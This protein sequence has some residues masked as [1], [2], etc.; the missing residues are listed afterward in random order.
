MREEAWVNKDEMLANL[1]GETGV[2]LEGYLEEEEIS[3]V[4]KGDYGIFY[5]ENRDSEPSMFIVK[6]IETSGSSMLNDPY[7]ASVY[8]GDI[9]VRLVNGD[10]LVSN[11]GLYRV[12]L[13]PE[14]DI[15]LPGQIVRGT[16]II[17]G[18]KQ[19]LLNQAWTRVFAVL[20]RE[21]GF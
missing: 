18:E 14:T 13:V 5:M 21:S 15:E 6:E 20:I 10:D 7:L 4:E 11:K 1:R 17:K 3:N 19:S 2:V 8:G 9:P 16:V 12:I